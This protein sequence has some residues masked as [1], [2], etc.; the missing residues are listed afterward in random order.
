MPLTIIEALIF[1]SG[2]GMHRDDLY[3]GLKEQ[4]SKKEIDAAIE[5]LR[6][7]YSGDRGMH[8][9]CANNI[10]QFQSELFKQKSPGCQDRCPSG[11]S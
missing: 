3:K 4:Y 8:L 1:A 7:Q 9:I 6:N 10:Y 2:H 11:Q 5:K